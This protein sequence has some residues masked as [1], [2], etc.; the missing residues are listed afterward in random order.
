MFLLSDQNSRNDIR[1]CS[2]PNMFTCWLQSSHLCHTHLPEVDP[3]VVVIVEGAFQVTCE[4]GLVDVFQQ[5][6]QR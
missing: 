5:G 3:V 6:F 1:A 2:N 4:L